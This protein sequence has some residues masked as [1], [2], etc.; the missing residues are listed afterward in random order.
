MNI[1][2]RT[3]C[4]QYFCLKFID[5][6]T[7]PL[8][9]LGLLF[10]IGVFEYYGIVVLGVFGRASYFQVWGSV[11]MVVL[12]TKEKRNEMNCMEIPSNL[13]RPRSRQILSSA[14]TRHPAFT[15][16]KITRP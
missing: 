16:I 7:I 8:N 14:Q 2:N 12:W 10:V 5:K 4:S 3:T 11:I 6:S 9:V 15:D 1:I 13:D